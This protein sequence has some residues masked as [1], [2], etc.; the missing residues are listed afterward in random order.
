MQKTL[1]SFVRALRASDIRV[2]PAETID[3]HRAA[4]AVGYGDRELFRDA[5][6]STL[7]KTASETARFDALIDKGFAA[8]LATL[9]DRSSRVP[10]PRAPTPDGNTV[11][12]TV[13]DRDRT[14]VS[15]INSLYG[16]F[17]C[18]IATETPAHSNIG[19]SFSPSPNTTAVDGWIPRCEARAAKAE[20][21]ETSVGMNSK[22][23]VL[24]RTA[25]IRGD[26][27]LDSITLEKSAGS[28]IQ[29]T[30]K[31]SRSSN[32]PRSSTTG[33]WPARSV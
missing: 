4:E 23:R 12:V 31:M 17:G 1:E 21:F 9:I 18:G 30:L 15:I 7:A 32:S 13:V 28:P 8:R 10:L 6:I 19:I 24:V 14:A 29:I 3:A 16:Q 33:R 20:P 5:L 2:S 11:Y 25:W 26:T 22:K 27:T